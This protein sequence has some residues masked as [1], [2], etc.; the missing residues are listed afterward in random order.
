MLFRRN[1]GEVIRSNSTDKE[2]VDLKEEPKDLE[3]NGAWTEVVPL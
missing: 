1:Y 3:E 2:A